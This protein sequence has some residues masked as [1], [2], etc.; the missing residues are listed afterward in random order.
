MRKHKTLKA[1]GATALA[2]ATV[3]SGLSFG[4][5]AASASA[6]P[7][8]TAA[9]ERYEPFVY[10]A[11]KNW[12]AGVVQKSPEWAHDFKWVKYPTEA[13]ARAA[14]V[15]I[16]VP[17]IG[18][19]ST[20]KV[21][22]QDLCLALSNTA[23][24][25]CSSTSSDQK[26]VLSSNGQLAP[27]SAPSRLM[28]SESTGTNIEFAAVG[29]AAAVLSAGWTNPVDNGGF[30]P[31]PGYDHELEAGKSMVMS[32]PVFTTTAVT[33]EGGLLALQAPEGTTFAK[34]QTLLKGRSGDGG[35]WFDYPALNVTGSVSADGKSFRAALPENVSL[36]TTMV[37]SWLI[38]VTAD[39]DAPDSH[40]QLKQSFVGTSNLGTFIVNGNTRVTVKASKNEFTAVG[41]FADDVTKKATISG[42]GVDGSTMKLYAPN[43][44]EIDS[45]TVSDGKYSFS[46]TAPGSGVQTFKV[47]QTTDGVESPQKDAPLDY[48]NAVAITGPATG[49]VTPGDVTVTGTGVSGSKVTIT[50]G[51]KTVTTTV[52]TDNTFS[53]PVEIAPSSSITNITVSQQ[54]K[55]NLTTTA[56]VKV[57]ADGKQEA[58]GTA[59]TGPADGV[60]EPMKTTT[61]TGT[62]TPYATVVIT[63]QWNVSIA[64]VTAGKDGTWSF[65]RVY[66]PAAEYQLTATQTRLDGSGSKSAAFALAPLGSFKNLTIDNEAPATYTAGKDYTFTGTAT[67][68]ATITATNQWG[69]KVFETRANQS[70]GTWTSTR[71]YGPT[72]EYT[73]T[74][75]QKALDGKTDKREGFV[76][77]PLVT[78]T[79]MTITSHKDGDSYRPGSNTFTG[80][81][82]PGATVT[83]RNQWNTVMGS[84]TVKE[85]GDWAFERTMGPS[86]P[87]TLTFTQTKDGK[88]INTVPLN[89]A[90]PVVQDFA[91]TSPAAGDTYTP[92]KATTFTGKASAFSKITVTTT[93]GTKVFE[94]EAD[95]KGDWS[96]TRAYGPTN[97]YTLN[98]DETTT[99]GTTTRVLK[100]FIFAPDAPATK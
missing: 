90:A 38:N 17:A 45:Q 95:Q 65:D 9:T 79:P 20:L 44:D 22:G 63:N 54:S 98:F 42:T 76:L 58:T 61:V 18:T 82:A 66:G 60:Y 6:A 29:T 28:Y 94:T 13:A 11:N 48:G 55:G 12:Y 81:G 96:Y 34:G 62:A 3:A 91:L 77:K 37:F 15:K 87:Y 51:A 43:G 84:A 73:L 32:V 41:A 8:S 14:A 23:F 4:A 49:S 47:S 24:V 88:T 92:M 53:A 2:A 72:A 25:G 85:N 35:R 19:P 27:Q 71:Q 83:A 86:A 50:G 31:S 75:V 36:P 7:T 33:V 80:V 64:T 70:N 89:L 97:T 39:A 16:S 1:F 74:F 78:E 99:N 40:G 67:P 10:T 26:F 56:A 21:E 57:T 46:V 100:N 30:E 59:I 68:G 69:T 52:G 5:T 93:L